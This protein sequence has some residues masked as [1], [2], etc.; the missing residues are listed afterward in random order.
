MSLTEFYAFLFGMALIWITQKLFLQIRQVNKMT[1]PMKP[2][3]DTD[4]RKIEGC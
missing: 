3:E 4:I 1:V 2:I